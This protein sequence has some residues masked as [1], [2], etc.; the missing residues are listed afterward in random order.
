MPLLMD[1]SLS[2]D[3]T[4][5]FYGPLLFRFAIQVTSCV[6]VAV[7]S[8]ERYMSMRDPSKEIMSST[9]FNP[10]SCLVAAICILSCAWTVFS[11]SVCYFQVGYIKN[12]GKGI[13]CMMSNDE[14]II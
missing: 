13:W 4:V 10:F 6:I 7:I 2:N 8:V 3:L 9:G 14:F 5:I 1:C 11:V 12:K